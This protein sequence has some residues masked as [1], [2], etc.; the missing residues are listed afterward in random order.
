MKPK[1]QFNHFHQ[2]TPAGKWISSNTDVTFTSKNWGSS[3]NTNTSLGS[4]DWYEWQAF[5][6]TLSC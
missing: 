6:H 5:G 2:T 3:P 4:G 1:K